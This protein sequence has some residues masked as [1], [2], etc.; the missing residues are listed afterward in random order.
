MYSYCMS[1]SNDHYRETLFQEMSVNLQ[2]RLPVCF[3][4]MIDT[5]TLVNSKKHV[6]DYS[7]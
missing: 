2:K 6:S 7:L 3:M 1:L 4:M 5:C